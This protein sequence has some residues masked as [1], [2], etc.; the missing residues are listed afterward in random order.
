MTLSELIQEKRV[1][2][3]CGAGGVGKTTVSAALGLAAARMGRRVLVV[4]IDPAKRLAE[5]L[6]VARNPPEPVAVS[7]DRLEAAGVKGDGSLHAWMLD[8]KLIAERVVRRFSSDEASAKRLLENRM[9]RN[10][11]AIVAGMQE[12]TAIE[13]L[14]RFIEDETFDLVVLDTPPSRNALQFLE[15]PS[16]AIGFLDGRIF[17]LF[18]PGEQNF[19]RRTAAKV[20][21][22]VMDAAFGTE[23]REELQSFLQGVGVVLRRVK[24]DV[25]SMQT[26]F[27]SDRVTFLLVSSPAAEAI[28][29]AHFF[30]DKVT[31]DLKMKVG[32][33]ILNGSLAEL[34]SLP[35]PSA[36]LLA[37]DASP[38]LRTAVEKLASLARVELEEARRHRAL[39]QT[40]K[41]RSKTGLAH[42]LPRLPRSVSDLAAVTSLA[43]ALLE[44][45]GSEAS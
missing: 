28:A 5:T 30:E 42:A 1:L 44:I 21:E 11:S 38:L 14:Y 36:A 22:R 15:A 39:L 31:H 4:T 23:T 13:A 20:V 35:F 3:C 24:A 7:R 6:G 32:G 29:E 2:V 10:I 16:R 26:T 8:P 17:Q 40:L 45:E 25:V 9:Y 41:T 19:F 37:E 27:R 43:N 18:L 33:Y 12:Y 34:E